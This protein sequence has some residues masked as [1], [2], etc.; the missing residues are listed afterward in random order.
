MRHKHRAGALA[1]ARKGICW[2]V[3]EGCATIRGA[4]TGTRTRSE[5]LG[6]G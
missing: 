4:T 6:E 5:D 1:T 3:L 2:E